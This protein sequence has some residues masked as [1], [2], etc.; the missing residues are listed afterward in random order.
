MKDLRIIVS[1]QE[2]IYALTLNSLFLASNQIDMSGK[3]ATQSEKH[4]SKHDMMDSANQLKEGN[5]EVRVN[6]KLEELEEKN[7]ELKELL[8]KSNLKLDILINLLNSESDHDN[9][10]DNS[11]DKTIE[12]DKMNEIENEQ[13]N[14]IVDKKRSVYK[15]LN[16]IV[17]KPSTSYSCMILRS[18]AQAQAKGPK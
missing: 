8:I 15:Q 3:I 12:Y 2:Q 9:I 13:L 4:A 10:E 11:C 17:E 18:N 7:E 5:F 1:Y 6:K 14:E 16:E